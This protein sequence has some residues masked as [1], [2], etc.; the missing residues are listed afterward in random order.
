[1]LEQHKIKQNEFANWLE[2]PIT[3]KVFDLIKDRLAFHRNNLENI[4]SSNNPDNAIKVGEQ[5]GYINMCKALLNVEYEDFN[6][7]GDGNE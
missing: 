7:E 6:T 1:M 4:P 3:K 5:I 2:E